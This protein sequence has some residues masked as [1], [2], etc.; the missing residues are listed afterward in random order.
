MSAPTDVDRVALTPPSG[1]PRF[2]PLPDLPPLPDFPGARDYP[3]PTPTIPIPAPTP[4]PTPRV[5]IDLPRPSP[6]VSVEPPPRP[7]PPS[8]APTPPRAPEP[9]T[10]TTAPPRPAPE[11]RW[12]REALST[13]LRPTR[14]KATA[15]VA[16]AALVGGAVGLQVV[17]S[18]PHKPATSA[19]ATPTEKQLSPEKVT[20]LPEPPTPGNFTKLFLEPMEASPYKSTTA[21]AAADP[22]QSPNTFPEPAKLASGGSA[23]HPPAP[24]MPAFETPKPIAA[25]AMP[26]PVRQASHEEPVAAPSFPAIPDLPPMPAAPPSPIPTV[27]TLPETPK[28][29]PPQPPAPLPAKG[30]APTIPAPPQIPGGMTLPAVG[31]IPPLKPVE[32]PPEKPID[33]PGGSVKAPAVVTP[34]PAQAPVLPVPVLPLP[35]K[36]IEALPVP[37]PVTPVQP[38]PAKD[39]PFKSPDLSKP[40]PVKL[41]P[42]P[43][44]VKVAPAAPLPLPTSA[45]DKKPEANGF[46]V[47]TPEAKP[48]PPVNVAPA[49]APALL[50]ATPA[51]VASAPATAPP[52]KGPVRTAVVVDIAAAKPGQTY[53]SL[54]RDHYQTPQYA[55]GLRRYNRDRDPA[56]T[57]IEL[58]PTD[59]LRRGDRPAPVV[60][61]GNTT[62]TPA[63][64]PPADLRP[65]SGTRSYSIPQDGTTFRDLAETLLGRRDRYKQISDLN[66]ARDPNET[67]K[68]GDTVVVPVSAEVRG[69]ADR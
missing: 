2:P 4:Q 53:E 36:P 68:K 20:D 12:V 56:R 15:L 1:T 33:L 30:D 27:P 47:P 65:A 43:E 52:P 61:A 19:A 17:F 13:L 5:T 39:S 23:G 28:P 63:D 16:A 32:K 26:N 48:L 55:D 40:A 14:P 62:W 29:V 8:P 3:G 60:A 49:P 67:L 10:L 34:V 11:G 51:P 46:I 38:E 42:P 50:P 18:Q 45:P 41:D 66:P 69:P 31:D 22:Y 7:M 58:P 21:I 54:S 44:S 6:T 35:P 37:L 64:R 9:V 25:A 59:V 24:A 57:D